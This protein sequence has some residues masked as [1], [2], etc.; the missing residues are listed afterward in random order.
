MILFFCFFFFSGFCSL[1]YQV[2]WLRVAMGGFG[3]TTPLISIVLSIFMAGLA[4]GSWAGGKLVKKLE[5]K[6]ARFFLGLYGGIELLIGVSGVVVAPLLRLG[7][8]LFGV[9]TAW[10]SSAYYLVSA[11]WIGLVMLPFCT[12]MG[13]TFPAAMAGI[14]GAFPN[15]SSRSFSYL[16]VANVVGAMTGVIASAF[17]LIE[18]MG[19]TRTLWT[20]AALNALIGLSAFAASRRF[21]SATSVAPTVT[22]EPAPAASAVSG[23]VMILPLLFTTGLASLAMEVVWTRQ[24]MP[25]LGPVVY[26]FAAMLAVYLAATAIGTRVYRAAIRRRGGAAVSTWNR[27]V[28][29]AG[30]FALGPLLAADPRLMQVSHWSLL[31][32]SLRVAAGIGPFCAALGFL[33]PMLVDR[34]SRGVP[35]RAG[36]AYAINAIGC[37]VGPLLA[38]FLLLPNLGERWTLIVLTLPL[39]VFGGWRQAGSPDGAPQ[40]RPVRLLALALSIALLLAVFSRDFATFYPGAR[41]GRDYTATVTA[42]GSGMR[43]RLLV[44]GLGMTILTPATKMMAHLPLASLA[45]PPRRVLVLCFGMGTSFRSSLSWGTPVTVVE[46][47]PSVPPLF[48][49]FHR[50][51]GELL[52]SPR[53]TVVIDDARRFLERSRDSFDVVIADPPPPPE[54]AGSSLLYSTEFY[55]AVARRLAHG[56]ILQTWL[57]AAGPATASSFAQALGQSFPVVRCFGSVPALGFHFLASFSPIE[58]RTA[59]ELAARVPPAAARDLLEWG[60]EANVEAQFQDTLRNELPLERLIAEDPAVPMLTDDRPVN[61]YYLLRDLAQRVR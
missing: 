14:R 57:S 47:V 35:N 7:H 39:F 50:D 38:G 2:V 26:S 20:A 18:L 56:G 46:L 22:P 48:G 9:Q 4:F 16:Y 53:A 32:G 61:E 5:R 23:D 44:N 12:L 43:K 41:I 42:Y 11:G 13:A 1:V 52:Q 15:R 19:F 10:D 3:A 6:S 58:K 55:R 28:I 29:V 40:R 51:A 34:W 60:P 25:F 37:I 49:Y 31:Y 8:A 27:V 36:T 33:T 24:F 45:A 17:V 59:A 54:A 21:A 30:V